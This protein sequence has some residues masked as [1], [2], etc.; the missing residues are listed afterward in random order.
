MVNNRQK[1]RCLH[2]SQTSSRYW[3]LKTHI[4]RK[5]QGRGRPIRED[6]WHSTYT[7]SSTATHY[8]PDMMMS[9]QNNNYDPNYQRHLYTFSTAQHKIEEGE[10]AFK[11]REPIT[12][13]LELGRKCVGW[14]RLYVELKNLSTQLWSTT[15]NFTDQLSFLQQP[16][17]STQYINSNFTPPFGFRVWF[18]HKCLTNSLHRVFYP[19][20]KQGTAIE[21]VHECN[22]HNIAANEYKQ[23][24]SDIIK[25]LKD[26]SWELLK[27]GINGSDTNRDNY[28]I[29]IELSDLPEE[30][31]KEK[32]LQL[33]NP[34]NPKTPISFWYHKE[35]HI[36][37]NLD[38]EDRND[39]TNHHWAGRAIEEGQTKLTEHE[40]SQFLQLVKT[41]T[42]AIFEIKRKGDLHYYFMAITNVLLRPP[43][44]N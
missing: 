31:E 29:C 6:E 27:F 1:W 36:E 42:F 40:L 19:T 14:L 20:N 32:V 41:A 4:R 13:T 34:Q 18:C 37:L 17:Q 44:F 33:T 43:T 12:E 10:E 9:M 16:L 3:N 23:N 25:K 5:H 7:T 35:K 38:S 8:I 39:N 2:C 30:K 28:V 24:K 22:P 26:S 11:K 21:D 15:P